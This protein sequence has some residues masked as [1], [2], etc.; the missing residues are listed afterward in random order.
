MR[1][2]NLTACVGML[3]LTLLGVGCASSPKPVALGAVEAET[4][5]SE[6]RVTAIGSL[7]GTYKVTGSGDGGGYV[8]VARITRLNDEVYHVEWNILPG[9]S[10][11][12]LGMRDG[13]TL[14][15]GIQSP[16]E[17]DYLG[18]VVYRISEGPTLEGR[19]TVAG[20]GGAVAGEVLE[21][22]KANP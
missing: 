11:F 7:A 4:E 12:G 14:A 18:V 15:V 10:F 1:Q 20:A 8:G 22:Q 6:S 17:P 21:F 5:E 13:N 3:W 19:W 9:A 2:W 16:R